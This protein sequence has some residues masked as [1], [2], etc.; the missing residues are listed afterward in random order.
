MKQPGRSLMKVLP[1]F[2][3]AGSAPAALYALLLMFGSAY[4]ADAAPNQTAIPNFAPDNHTSWHPDRPD[5]DDVLP[6]EDGAGPIVSRPDHPYVPNGERDFAATNPTYRI[7]D[8]TNSI[9]Q[10]WAIEQMKRDN[11]AVLAGKIP[12]IARERCYPG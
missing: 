3:C 12:F 6:A 5:G 8:L 2:R 10:P 11:D 7:A 9:L 1:V 4:A